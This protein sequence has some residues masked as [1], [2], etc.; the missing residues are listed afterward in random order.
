MYIMEIL[1][2][3]EIALVWLQA[4]ICVNTQFQYPHWG[5][6]LGINYPNGCKRSFFIGNRKAKIT[7]KFFFS[8]CNID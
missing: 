1:S 8:C 2:V 6:N 3:T 7:F 5:A 4:L